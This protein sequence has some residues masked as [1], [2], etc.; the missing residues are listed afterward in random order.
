MSKQCTKFAVSSFS[1]SRDILG[2]IQKLNG[3]HDHNDTPFGG[4]F[5]LF[6]KT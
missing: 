6:G 2:E 5:Y 1:R 4:D 3:S